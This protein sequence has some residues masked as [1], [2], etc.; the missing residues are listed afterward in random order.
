MHLL[1]CYGMHEPYLGGMEIEPVG[2][3]T[4]QGIPHDGHVQSVGMRRMDTQL[5]GTSCAGVEIDTD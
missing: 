4:V 2:G 3:Y 1:F 5:M